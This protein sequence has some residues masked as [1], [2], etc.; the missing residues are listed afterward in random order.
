MI[1]RKDVFLK[2]GFA[3][4][5]LNSYTRARILEDCFS[6]GMPCITYQKLSRQFCNDSIPAPSV[7]PAIDNPMSEEWLTFMLMNYLDRITHGATLSP[8][9]RVHDLY[10]AL[11][12][13]RR[14]N[15]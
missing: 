11:Y 5:I 15:K 4:M 12:V 6:Y 7:C 1:K 3:V 10:E 9:E 13:F 2:N 8:A 14:D